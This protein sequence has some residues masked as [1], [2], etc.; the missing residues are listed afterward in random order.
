MVRGRH[1]LCLLILLV[2]LFVNRQRSAF[3]TWRS[4]PA[5][6]LRANLVIRFNAPLKQHMPLGNPFA[7]SASSLIR[8]QINQE[9]LSMNQTWLQAAEDLKN[10]SVTVRRAAMDILYHKV[11][12]ANSS[13]IMLALLG[14]TYDEDLQVRMD[15]ATMFKRLSI[16]DR[17][18]CDQFLS[19][20]AARLGPESDA[21]SFERVMTLETLSR[22]GRGAKNYC[23]YMA[24]HLEHEDW[25]VRL[26]AVNALGAMGGEINYHK[27]FR[28]AVI[29]TRD[30][31]AREEVRKAADMVLRQRKPLK[32][33]WM[34]EQH[35]GWQIR[36]LRA[37][38]KGKH[39]GKS[40][41]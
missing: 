2:S 15:A 11:R 25:L 28:A 13:V 37:N 10:E 8:H 23:Q 5:R 18:Q 29:R 17:Y 38:T 41:R 3:V 12:R 7:T 39:N 32:P 1:L 21:D 33:N 14:A 35:P 19:R 20:I 9:P 27:F 40:K 34:K 31:D 16:S 4:H 6:V 36:V 24:D 26:S 22:I 30:T